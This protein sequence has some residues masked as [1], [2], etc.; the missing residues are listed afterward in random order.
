MS[1]YAQKR[2]VGDPATVAAFAA[3]VETPERLRMLLVITIADIRAV[4]PGRLER[5]EGSAAARALRR[6]RNP[7][8]RRPHLGRGRRRAAAAGGVR[9]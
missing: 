5:L 1:D 3:I 8:P 4:G 2:D 7:V 9:L 6:H